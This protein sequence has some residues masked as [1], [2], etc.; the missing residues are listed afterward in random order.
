MVFSL[1]SYLLA[2]WECNKNY[3]D[4]Q[5]AYTSSILKPYTLDTCDGG[6]INAM[7]AVIDMKHYKYKSMKRYKMG[8]HEIWY[9]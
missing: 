7:Q 2:Y 8:V 5:I 9:F 3:I 6:H 1:L 4:D